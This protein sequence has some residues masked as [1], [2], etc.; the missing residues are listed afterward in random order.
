MAS[1]FEPQELDDVEIVISRATDGNGYMA[2]IRLLDLESVSNKL[3]PPPFQSLDKASDP[4]TY[5]EQLFQWL[6]QD[7]V[8]KGFSYARQL[9][10]EPTRGFK[11]GTRLRLR[12]SLDP[13]SSELRHLCWESL[14]TPEGS[15]PFSLTTAFSRFIRT[16][17]LRGGPF[18]ER[19]LRM[20]LAISKPEGMDGS[21]LDVVSSDLEKVIIKDA[22]AS[23]RQLLKLD[24]LQG[25]PTLDR[26]HAAVEKGYHIVHLLAHTEFHDEQGY[27]VLSDDAGQ[28]QEVSIE[29]IVRTFV[30]PSQSPPGLVFLGVPLAAGNQGG[31]TLVNLAQMLIEAGVQALVAI[32]SPIGASN[33]QRFIERFYSALVRTGVIDLAVAEARNEIYRPDNWEWTY[34]VL[35]MRMPDGRLFEPLSVSLENEITGI[36]IGSLGL[37]DG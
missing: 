24:R 8:G 36:R 6:F 27:L 32:R 19:P 21:T 12:L 9:A 17:G 1:S 4:L 34:P 23:L 7:E 22:T 5:G 14:Y 35:Y 2:N 20:L 18:R 11:S 26:I 37:K 30:S 28:A 13:G 3:P 25:P 10:S 31:A 29:T 33:L 15:L 16:R